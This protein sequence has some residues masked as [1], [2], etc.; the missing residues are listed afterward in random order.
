MQ[1]LSDSH[2]NAHIICNEAGKPLT[3][4]SLANTMAFE[5]FVMS[6]GIIVCWLF[7]F[8]IGGPL[9]CV[10]DDGVI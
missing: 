2:I 7:H 4:F 5:I 1:G 8:V 3:R 10:D 9:V 6:N